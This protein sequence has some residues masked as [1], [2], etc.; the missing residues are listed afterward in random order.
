MEEQE[1][2]ENLFD[3]N[4]TNKEIIKELLRE[5]LAMKEASSAKRK[6]PSKVELCSALKS[7]IGE[8]L[9]CYKI[10]G[11]DI[12]GQPISIEATHNRMEK[13]AIDNQFMDEFGKFM[14]RRGGSSEY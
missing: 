1:E 7:T 13:C 9:T 11:F 2:G 3:E 12:D 8:F 4:Q 10:I 5:A 6:K 14:V